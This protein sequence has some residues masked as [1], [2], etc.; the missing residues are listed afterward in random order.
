MNW[1]VRSADRRTAPRARM[2]RRLHTDECGQMVAALLLVF[3]ALLGSGVL[4]LLVGKG[5][6][7]RQ[8]AVTAAD[9]A[10]LAAAGELRDQLI[11]RLA[12]TA[13][14]EP[15][16]LDYGAA[17]RA[18]EEYAQRNGAELVDFQGRALEVTVTTATRDTVGSAELPDLGGRRVPDV[19]AGDVSGTAT[20]RAIVQREGGAAQAAP[21]AVTPGAA[22]PSSAGP[23]A[24]GP[25]AAGLPAGGSVPAFSALRY[26]D[27]DGYT[28]TPS[29]SGLQPEMRAEIVKIEVATGQRLP[30]TSGYRS[31]AGQARVCA[32]VR[33]RNPNALCAPPGHSLH[34]AGLAID[35][36]EP[37]LVLA[38]M[39]QDPSIA[40]CQPFPARDAVHFAHSSG[41]ECGGARGAIPAG[42]SAA[43]VADYHVRLVSVEP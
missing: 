1:T 31:E 27:G 33:G 23:P 2:L 5:S 10:A 24:A 3:G 16:V 12:S 42:A 40:L 36:A 28:S 15:V 37:A 41:R 20:A 14:E 35:V 7:L 29:V 34:Q 43:A 39:R 4:L 18:A 19:R 22:G 9:S 6:V 38:A 13:F 21:G 25:P 32:Q 8:E 30:L 17:R 26:Y 11:A